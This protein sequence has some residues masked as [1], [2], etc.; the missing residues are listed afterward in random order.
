MKESMKGFLVV[1]LVI[2]VWFMLSR[3]TYVNLY[4]DVKLQEAQVEAALQR[5]NDLIPNLVA[6]VKGYAKHEESVFTEIANARASLSGS[7]EANNIEGIE[8]AS[9]ELSNTLNRLLVIS[10][11][12]PELK[13]N[14][15]F[16]A[17]QDELAG[18]ENRINVAWQYYNEAVIEYNKAV[19]SFPGSTIAKLSGYEPLPYF[20]ADE[21]AKEVPVVSF[22]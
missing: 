4:E 20:E 13:A 17:L 2:V 8:E 11:A 21:E 9:K 6:T 19:K 3:N 18:T 22:D 1:V 14:Q 16:I 12:Y 5:R 7:I 15:Q 10:E